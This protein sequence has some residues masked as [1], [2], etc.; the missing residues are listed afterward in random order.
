[1]PEGIYKQEGKRGTT[2]RAVVSAGTDPVTGRRRQLVRTFRTEREAIDWRLETLQRLRAGTYSEPSKVPLG[3]YLTRWLASRQDLAPS[4][5]KRYEGV[6]R[7]HIIP[8]LGHVPLGELRPD[9]IQDLYDR[10]AGTSIPFIMHA[11]LHPALDRARRL[12]MI[13]RDILD[14]VIVTGRRNIRTGDHP[15]RWWGWTELERF[16]DTAREQEPRYYPLVHTLAATGLR[17]SEALRLRWEDVDLA[18]GIVRVTESKTPAGRRRVTIDPD[19]VAVLR[20]HWREQTMRREALGPAWHDGGLVF[21]CGDG[22][23]MSH[24]T[25]AHAMDRIIRR[26]EVP[27]LTIHDL[28]HVHASLLLERGRPMHYVQRRLGHASITQTLGTYAHIV[29]QTDAAD[30]AAFGDGLRQARQQRTDRGSEARVT[31]T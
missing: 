13:H 12:G 25:I 7:L 30:A 23:P 8:N 26:A 20:D 29:P 3:E 21:D 28:R 15:R 10:R 5:R 19:T 4:S 11:I 18:A 14:G 31:E 2:Y 22:R 27:R 6:L 17:I 9:H 1:M 16:L 24:R